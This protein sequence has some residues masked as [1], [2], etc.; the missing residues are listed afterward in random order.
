M[1]ARD[2]QPLHAE[3]ACWAETGRIADFWLRDDDAVEPTA[4]L[5][6]LLALAARHAIPV[7]L[8]VIPASAQR[9]LAKRL[10]AEDKVAIAVHGWAHRNHAPENE[11]K[12]ELG[13]HRPQQV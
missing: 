2:W 10:Q 12:Q 5:D 7:V 1:T 11:K 4:A 8:A 6:R 13:A 3:L 9:T